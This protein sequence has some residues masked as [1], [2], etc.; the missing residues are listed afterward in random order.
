MSEERSIDQLLSTRARNALA[1]S[2][3]E[4]IEQ[5]KSAYPDRL[6]RIPGFGLRAFREIEA[7]FFPGQRY[8]PK[9]RQYQLKRKLYLLEDE[10]ANFLHFKQPSSQD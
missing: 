8:A 2:G 1:R 4:T 10:L 6:L 9:A 7:H 5:I 3:I